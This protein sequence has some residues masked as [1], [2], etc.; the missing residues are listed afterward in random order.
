MNLIWSGDWLSMKTRL[1]WANLIKWSTYTSTAAVLLLRIVLLSSDQ[2]FSAEYMR[3]SRTSGSELARQS[4]KEGHSTLLGKQ[5][6]R[7][8][9]F[10][11]SPSN[12][13]LSSMMSINIKSTL[14][15]RM[16]RLEKSSLLWRILCARKTWRSRVRLIDIIPTVR[17]RDRGREE[18]S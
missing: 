7:S 14:S 15:T 9:T 18:T 17:T 4:K 11:N 6:F 8:L 10:T 13:A 16:I 12:Y 1:A 5:S 2:M 3:W